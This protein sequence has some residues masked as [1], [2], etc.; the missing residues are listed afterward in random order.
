[1]L[2]VG[3]MLSANLSLK[4]S[5]VASAPVNGKRNGFGHSAC[6]CVHVCVCVC[7]H[8]RACMYVRV[9]MHASKVIETHGQV[10]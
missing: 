2:S 7:V 4:M 8:V 5:I 10:N 6:A 1:M 3:K 9:R